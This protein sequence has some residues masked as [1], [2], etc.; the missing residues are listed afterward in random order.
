MEQRKRRKV[1]TKNNIKYYKESKINDKAKKNIYQYFIL[2]KK[3]L[4]Q[5]ANIININKK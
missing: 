1:E 5:T 2:Y 4:K 3:K